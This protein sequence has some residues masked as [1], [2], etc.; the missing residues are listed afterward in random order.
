MKINSEL[1]KTLVNNSLKY[2]MFQGVI[3][4]VITVITGGTMALLAIFLMIGLG[5]AHF[6]GSVNAAKAV[7]DHYNFKIKNEEDEP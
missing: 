2:T 6:S 4:A 1:F 5:F 7:I 3:L